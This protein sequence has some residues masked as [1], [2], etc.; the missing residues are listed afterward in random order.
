M[1]ACFFII[2]Y[3]KNAN[4]F[5]MIIPDFFA[6]VVCLGRD[7]SASVWNGCTEREAVL[8]GWQML[9][10]KAFEKQ[11]F[12]VVTS[13][14]DTRL[15]KLGSRLVMPRSYGSGVGLP[16]SIDLDISSSFYAPLRRV[17]PAIPHPEGGAIVRSFS[18][19]SE[20]VV[21]RVY[22]DV[23]CLCKAGEFGQD[24]WH[25]EAARQMKLWWRAV[26]RLM[27]SG[28]GPLDIAR[29]Y[30]KAVEV[31]VRKR[32]ARREVVK[33]TTAALCRAACRGGFRHRLEDCSIGDLGKPGM[34]PKAGFREV[35]VS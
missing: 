23:R 7:V 32:M 21:Y 1:S 16:G 14:F 29:R 10:W 31:G 19:R 13:V 26:F 27:E 22:L 25:K 17:A 2:M 6:R 5:R 20:G 18:R 3:A 24:C 33:K 15:W 11:G 12:V 9:A 28:E 34:N 30:E 4:V 35:K 8:N